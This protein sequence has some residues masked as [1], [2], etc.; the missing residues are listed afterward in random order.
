[1]SDYYLVPTLSNNGK[2]HILTN[3][4]MSV[5]DASTTVMTSSNALLVNGNMTAYGAYSTNAVSA[6]RIPHGNSASRPTSNLSPGYIRYNTDI[7][8][9]EY[10]KS[11]ASIWLPLYSPPQLKTLTTSNTPNTYI[12]QDVSYNQYVYLTGINF[13][14]SVNLVSFLGADG[15]NNFFSPSV[16]WNSYTS[17]TAQ[18][19]PA[20]YTGQGINTASPYSVTVSSS[21]SGM[22]SMLSS[23]LYVGLNPI[24]VTAQYPST[25]AT[26]YNGQ[27]YGAGSAGS[28][29]SGIAAYM[30]AYDPCGNSITFT[31]DPSNNSSYTSPNSPGGTWSLSSTTFNAGTGNYYAYITGT[32]GN[33]T[34]TSGNLSPNYSFGVIAT[35]SKGSFSKG[36]FKVVINPYYMIASVSA[37]SGT[38]A[39]VSPNQITASSKTYSMMTNTNITTTTYSMTVTSLGCPGTVSTPANNRLLDFLLVGGGGGGGNGYQGGGGGAGGVISS[40][41]TYGYSGGGTSSTVG[42][43]TVSQT[44]TYIIQVGGGGAGA[45]FNGTGTSLY[46]FCGGNTYIQTP[47]STIL[48]TA[49][50]GGS[51][52]GEQNYSAPLYD[53]I[54]FNGGC[55]GGGSH[56]G[57][58]YSAPFY[59]FGTAIPGTIPV[60][61]NNSDIQFYNRSYPAYQAAPVIQG[62][63]GGPGY[64]NSPYVGG[65]GG[66]AGTVGGPALS[67]GTPGNGGNGVVN[68]ITGSSITYGGGGGGA[69]RNTGPTTGSGGS[70]GGGAG[71]N[72]ATTGISGGN[73]TNG[74]GGGGGAVGL[75]GG[76]SGVNTNSN[77][78]AG[79]TPSSPSTS[80]GTAGSG[81]NGICI[82]RFGASATIT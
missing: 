79:T 75:G 24:F 33:T 40:S 70:G 28:S 32:V 18:V 26:Y 3:G 62:C 31:V 42:T 81:G 48:Y 63:N 54:C 27:T 1:M 51:G 58:S 20:S 45:I 10:Y 13:D 14:S 68:T 82:L 65:G 52:T 16:I 80:T 35:N 67:N 12:F 46:P 21:L 23:S 7:N 66:G 4:K 25:L 47:S 61:Y 36:L 76:A 17:L 57:S 22:S 77:I 49:Y 8:L 6:M 53:Y 15:S 44:G 55:G 43:Y 69:T 38:G 29:G 72:S 9:V 59:G 30:E 5:G 71:N 73:G 34:A 64:T 11:S 39:T 41:A 78:S 2:M 56:A 74:L 19:P 50:G 37:T 60:G